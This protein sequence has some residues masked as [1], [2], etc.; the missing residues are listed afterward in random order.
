MLGHSSNSLSNI[1]EGY[2]LCHYPTFMRK[3]FFASLGIHLLRTCQL[4]TTKHRRN[5]FLEMVLH[6]ASTCIAFTGGYYMNIASIGL[7][8]SVLMDFCNLWVH[9]AKAFSGTTYKNTCFF[10]G[11]GMWL[12]WMYTRIVSFPIVFVHTL[13]Y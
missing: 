6:H 11:G 1:F 3:F 5:D 4:V 12:F 8:V 7:L 9:F 10:F 13:F 2:P